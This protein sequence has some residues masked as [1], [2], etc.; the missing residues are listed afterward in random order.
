M[1]TA[2]KSIL[3]VSKDRDA[4]STRYR[5]QGYFP[6]LRAAGWLPR[7]LCVSS[8]TDQAVLLSQARLADLVVVL[9]R[10]LSLPV[11]LLL[12]R[13]SRRLVFDFDDAIFTH[14]DGSPSRL[15][16]AGFH[17]M[18][19]R[20]N[21]VFAGNTYL[22]RHASTFTR[23]V[24]V[25]PTVLNPAEYS[26]RQ[27]QPTRHTDLVWIGSRSTERYLAEMIPVLE[28]LFDRNPGIRLKIIADFSLDSKHI[29]ILPVEWERTTEA[30]HL[31]SAHVGIAPMPEDDWTLGKCGLKTLQ[32][33]AAGLPVVASAVGVHHDLVH[34]DATGF[35]VRTK[36]DWIN[37]L[38]CLILDSSLRHTMGLAGRRRLES[39]FTVQSMWPKMQA[40]LESLVER[41]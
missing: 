2:K 12:R 17:A 38:Q 22:A 13:A 40:V 14:N 35:L 23:H 29:P 15:R 24:T 1:H 21:H 11:L 8:F 10:Q 25:L 41:Q 20:C 30:G 5:A 18:V 3:F 34:K 16:M 26:V 31:T 9:R 19:R 7:H 6:Y 37:A 32:Y 39:S 28:R 27:E 36:D 4:A 33:M